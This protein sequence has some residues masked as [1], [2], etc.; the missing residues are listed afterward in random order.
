M[1]WQDW[2]PDN[3]FWFGATVGFVLGWIIAQLKK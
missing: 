3:L 1:E 2:D